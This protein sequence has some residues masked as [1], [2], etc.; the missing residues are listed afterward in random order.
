MRRYWKKNWLHFG[1][2][3]DPTSGASQDWA[4]EN[5]TPIAYTFELR[6]RGNFIIRVYFVHVMPFDEHNTYIWFLGQ[7]GFILPADQIVVTA[8]ELLDGF[9]VLVQTA[10]EL[11]QL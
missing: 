2:C 9:V 6:D 4:Y 1:N 11:G 3:L 10:R 7:H 5:G 8:R